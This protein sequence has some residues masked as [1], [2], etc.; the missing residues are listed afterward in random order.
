MAVLD[1][2]G[3]MAGAGVSFNGLAFGPPPAT[4]REPSDVSYTGPTRSRRVS[5]AP[6]LQGPAIWTL[7]WAIMDLDDFQSLYT[8][9]NLDI[10]GTG[11][12]V[13]F[14]INDPRNAGAF[15][16]ADYWMDEPQFSMAELYVRNVSVV[17]TEVV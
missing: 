10:N 17:L 12:R 1:Q 6:V 9:W 8:L 11:T 13:A 3:G 4:H 7:S 15:V 5:G 14:G 16:V 2:F